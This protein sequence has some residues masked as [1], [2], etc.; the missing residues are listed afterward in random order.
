MTA[1]A[2]P[3]RSSRRLNLKEP[4]GRPDGL[5]V[6]PTLDSNTASIFGPVGG[7]GLST[8]R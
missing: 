8:S 6:P 3:K 5:T 7:V 1:A 2:M 4:A